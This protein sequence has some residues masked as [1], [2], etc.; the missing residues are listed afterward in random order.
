MFLEFLNC[1]NNDDMVGNA[2][3]CCSYWP[4]FMYLHL[5]CF[6]FCMIFCSYFH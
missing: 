2:E 4:D 6:E 5:R 3:I 1:E